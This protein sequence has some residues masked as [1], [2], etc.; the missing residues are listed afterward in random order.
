[1]KT[2]VIVNKVAAHGRAATTW[3]LI[4]PV[5]SRQGHEYDWAETE[6]PGHA[7]ELARGAVDGGYQRI[8]ALGGD[9]TIHETVNGMAGTNVILGVIPAG[10]GNDFAKSLDLPRSPLAALA[11]IDSGRVRRI[12]LA[13]ANDRYYVNVGGVGF[14]AEV[15]GE[16]N[17]IPKYIQG[18]FAYLVAIL[19][20]LPRYDPVPLRIE[21]DG[22]RL[23]ERCL[24]VAAG[25]GRYTGGGLKICPGAAPDDG[26][27]DVIVGGNFGKMETLA[28][29]PRVFSG[30]HVTHPKVT[31]YQA[32]RVTI[33]SAIPLLVYADGEILGQ[34]PVTFEVIPGALLVAG[35]K[36]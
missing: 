19:R 6:R 30:T 32:S 23:E 15:A 29:L 20:I 11:A 1:M 16:A 28:V 18:A 25:N 2:M 13:R 36:G 22:Q 5:I 4:R 27:L 12:D 35:A 21:L 17:R 33:N 14:D 10:T 31:S 34:T 26:L 24:L 3:D 9:G 7:T 8:I